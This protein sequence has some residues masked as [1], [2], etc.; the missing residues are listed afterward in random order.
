MESVPWIGVGSLAACLGTVVPRAYDSDHDGCH[1]MNNN[2]LYD[3]IYMYIMNC[4][5]ATRCRAPVQEHTDVIKDARAWH[6]DTDGPTG[7][8]DTWGQGGREEREG[9][10]I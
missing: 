7:Y 9:E 8:L 2:E 6:S 10:R 1:T 4:M 3:G 5:M